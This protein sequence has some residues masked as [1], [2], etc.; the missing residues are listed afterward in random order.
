MAASV[1]GGILTGP[2]FW[3]IDSDS[4][5]AS[6]PSSSSN[7]TRSPSMSSISPPSSGQLD[8]LAPRWSAKRS[9]WSSTNAPT[10]S[11]LASPSPGRGPRWFRA[12]GRPRWT[13]GARARSPF[14][15]PRGRELSDK[16]F[17]V[18]DDRGGVAAKRRRSSSA[19]SCTVLGVLISCQMTSPGAARKTGSAAPPPSRRPHRAGAPASRGSRTT[20]SF[21][22]PGGCADGQRQST[23]LR[24][25]WYAPSGRVDREPK[26][27]HGGR[28]RR[29]GAGRSRR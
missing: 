14:D 7:F 2:G 21:V 11:T 9:R 20:R 22:T 26:H 19:S 16:R 12:R 29:G 5:L 6:S 28:C 27:A 17:D 10:L 13:R 15:Q 18:A 25:T 8:R 3:A 4:P 1:T 23:P 24:A